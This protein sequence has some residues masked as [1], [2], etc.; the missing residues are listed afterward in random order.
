MSEPQ[1]WLNVSGRQRDYGADWRLAYEV[2]VH[3]GSDEF[4]QTFS[5]WA[6]RNSVQLIPSSSRTDCPTS[7]L[8]EAKGPLQ[9]R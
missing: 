1:D 9:F 4:H 7:C 8:L 5:T 2:K 3:V 6:L